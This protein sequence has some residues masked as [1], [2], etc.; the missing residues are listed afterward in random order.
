M[1]VKD[2]IEKLKNFPDDAS[3]TINYTYSDNFWD[4]SCSE[5]L[6]DVVF[7][8]YHNNVDIMTKGYKHK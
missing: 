8:E 4:V 3:V 2:L 1:F 5:G 7:D 6:E